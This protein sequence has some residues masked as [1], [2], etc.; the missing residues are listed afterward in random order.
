M[1]E[2]SSAPTKP[3]RPEYLQVPLPLANGADPTPDEQKRAYATSSSKASS[4][5][6]P[7]PAPRPAAPAKTP[8]DVLVE[9]AETVARAVTARIAWHERELQRLRAALAPFAGS[10]RH[11]DADHKSSPGVEADAEFLARVVRQLSHEN[12]EG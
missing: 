9:A 12:G 4:L 3:A 11:N 10:Q 5:P 7:D 1:A 8:S 2:A 6:R